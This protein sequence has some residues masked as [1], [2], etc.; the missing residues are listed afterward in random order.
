MLLRYT[1]NPFDISI[2]RYNTNFTLEESPFSTYQQMELGPPVHNWLMF[3]FP[4]MELGHLSQNCIYDVDS[5]IHWTKYY[6]NWSAISNQ[7][8]VVY[9]LA[10]GNNLQDSNV[11]VVI[12][13]ICQNLLNKNIKYKFFKLPHNKY[14][15]DD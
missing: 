5:R 11:G 7:S 15:Y 8:D 2:A 10:F 3:H 12:Y 14:V 13:N 9:S 1:V 4:Y 6:D